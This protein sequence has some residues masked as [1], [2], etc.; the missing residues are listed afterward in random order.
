MSAPATS[1]VFGQGLPGAPG[2]DGRRK[3]NSELLVGKTG[4]PGLPG[5]NGRTGHPGHDGLPDNPPILG[6]N[7]FDGYPGSNGL[8][9][10]QGHTGATGDRVVAAG[11]R[12]VL[13]TDTTTNSALVDEIIGQ[14][15]D[16]ADHGIEQG[17][18]TSSSLVVENTGR[19]IL[20]YD[21][22]TQGTL[23]FGSLGIYING[24]LVKSTT[25]S[26]FYSMNSL[27]LAGGIEN[28]TFSDQNI[29]SI[30]IISGVF[31]KISGSYYTVTIRYPSVF[32]ATQT[33][34]NTLQVQTTAVPTQP[35]IS[36]TIVE[37]QFFFGSIDLV[38]KLGFTTT[39]DLNAG[40]AVDVKLLT[41][42][43]GS[44]TYLSMAKSQLVLS[45]YSDIL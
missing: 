25:S 1:I 43:F 13:R 40:D 31:V 14:G 4:E 35:T 32:I 12:A 22:D 36:T 30:Q 39:L 34:P 2:K 45:Y 23:T 3:V 6:V 17:G 8:I 9:G 5:R 29:V 18:V 26:K 24:T 7:Y 28:V 37:T 41:I 38:S 42:N 27:V 16:S 21:I 33:G 20:S 15:R 11:N 19:Y 44:N 10:N